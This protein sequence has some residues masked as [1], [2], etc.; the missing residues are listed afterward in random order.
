MENQNTVCPGSWC[1][2]RDLA[3]CKSAILDQLTLQAYLTVL[4]DVPIQHSV[5]GPREGVLAHE[6]GL[7][8][9]VKGVL[10]LT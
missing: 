6:L 4:L 1:N 9:V 3:Q 2:P 7:L 10:A 5:T 8:L